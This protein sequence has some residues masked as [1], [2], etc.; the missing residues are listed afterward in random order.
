MNF[1]I[2]FDFAGLSHHTLLIGR[3]LHLVFMFERATLNREYKKTKSNTNKN[4][5]FIITSPSS[6]SSSEFLLFIPHKSIR[7]EISMKHD[8]PGGMTLIND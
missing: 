4:K 1:N 5:V 3:E 8:M 2:K 6:S 7:A